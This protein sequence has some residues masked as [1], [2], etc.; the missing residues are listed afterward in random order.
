MQTQFILTIDIGTSGPK[1]ALFDI[2]GNCMGYEFEPV[3][4]NLSEGGGAEQS[5]DAWK[6]AIKLCYQKLIA[7]TRTNPH[8]IIAIN[9]T[10][11]WSGTIPIDKEGKPLMDCIN[12][13]DSRG[14]KQIKNLVGGFP[15]IDGYAVHKII[16]WIYLT[17]GGPSKAG[18]DSLAHILWLKENRPD[19]YEK[20]YKFLEPKD[21]INYW[22]TGI[23]AASYDSITV[24]WVTD[25][26]DINNI[27]YSD[28]LLNL[29]G[30]ERDKLPDLVPV[31][32]ILGK[33]RK[34]IA[35]EFGLL[36]TIPV[37]AGT[38][39]LH[40]AAVG[41]G[42]VR[43]FQSHLY[44]G[45][46]SWLVC[47]VPFKKTDLF[48]NMATI[49]SALPGRY[50]VANEQ[51]TTGA[52]L[53]FVKNNLL[54]AQDELNQNPAPKDFYSIVDNI[55]ARTPAGSEGLIFLPWLYGERSPI[56]DH[57]A[58]GGFYNLSLN[59]TRADMFR[60]VFE[61]VALNNRWLL[62]YLEKMI[63][64]KVESINFIG[65]GAN[66]AVWSQ[67]IADVYNIPVRQMK[68][69]LMAN[70]RGTA[71][72]ALLALNLTDLETISETVPHQMEF[73]PNPNHRALYDE[74]FHIFL[75]IYN[76][77]KGIFARLNA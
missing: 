23:I 41:S 1:V 19:I 33:I 56:D 43:D 68:E 15:E 38:P 44:I 17:G 67:I 51:E 73:I 2:K 74:R 4:L 50:I 72:L 66:S 35:D 45:T 61:G 70:S 40:S 28:E 21:F 57:H 3:A 52:C 71:L 29:C 18:K 13:M 53:N 10:T 5:P 37:I 55:V 36:H 58:R 25:N 69:P 30:I 8:H 12:W 26:R 31:N 64:R 20:T 77:N 34:E 65:G 6:L 62:M 9:C 60:A 16:K 63:N 42:A 76:K 75:E 46:S 39:D 32:S 7:H 49:P 47:H 54:Y 11:Q 48:H 27:T 22:L 24:H 59:N 14:A